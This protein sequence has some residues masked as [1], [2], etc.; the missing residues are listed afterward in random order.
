[1][2]SLEK[3]ATPGVEPYRDFAH[4]GPGTLAGRLMRTF[5]HPIY[6]SDDLPP[7]R[8]VPRRIMGEDFTLYRGESGTAHVVAF[9]CA[10]RGTQL[11][12]GWVEGDDLRCFYHGWK[13]NAEGQCIEQPAEPEPFCNRIRIKSFPTHEYLGLIFAYL[14]EGDPPPFRRFP[15]FEDTE[16]YTVVETF[17]AEP[18]PYNFFN[19][20]EN[21][22]PHIPFVHR[23]TAS[24]GDMISIWATETEYG[25]CDHTSRSG[26]Q[27]VTH[28][29]MPNIRL[30][31][32]FP[33]PG[34]WQERLNFDVPVDDSS[35]VGFALIKF[36]FSSPEARDAWQFRKPG[37]QAA[38]HLG[39]KG[40]VQEGPGPIEIAQRCLAGELNVHDIT[41]RGDLVLIQDLV[42]QGGQGV[43]ADRVNEHLGRSDSGV[44]AWRRIW[45]RE[46]RAL[47]DGRPLR[48]WP[49]PDLLEM[50]GAFMG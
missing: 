8:A 38:L 5:W 15:Q 35:H 16:G 1:M 34:G 17:Y 46:L 47:A 28:R 26:L 27:N 18:Q 49:I 4:T 44:I 9:R 33:P 41:G 48:Q 45:E 36:H 37:A 40:T 31:I 14:G 50:N 2:A 43:I 12:T 19:K 3:P 29:I 11:S 21:D 24:F 30:F 25:T 22:P 20:L 6:R 32:S 10:H 23:G 39:Q 7:G 42:S 13:Y